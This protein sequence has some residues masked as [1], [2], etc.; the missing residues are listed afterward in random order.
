M[1]LIAHTKIGARI[2]PQKPPGHALVTSRGSRMPARASDQRQSTCP[3]R[4]RQ[5]GPHCTT[6]PCSI[7]ASLAVETRSHSPSVGNPLLPARA[8]ATL[9]WINPCMFHERRT[10]LPSSTF[11]SAQGSAITHVAS[12]HATLL[13]CARGEHQYV[14]NIW[15]KRNA[16]LLTS[17][18]RIP[19]NVA[20][21]R[22]YRPP[23]AFRAAWASCWLCLLCCE[24][25]N[26]CSL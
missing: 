4:A 5:C 26:S 16:P 14:S 11:Y 20:C 2:V 15:L 6:L 13:M 18:T 8:E 19:P 1:T 9:L 22:L 17:H 23:Y 24:N 21:C 25:L 7:A 10:C 3:L 12:A